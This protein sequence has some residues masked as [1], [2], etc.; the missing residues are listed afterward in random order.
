MAFLKA[1]KEHWEQQQFP[2]KGA[3]ILVAVSGGRDS[4][5]LAFV[6]LQCEQPIVVAH[7]NYQL[8]GADSDADEALVT[9]WCA[10]NKVPLFVK[11]FD[12][13][14]EMS[15]QKAGV[16]ETARKLRYDWF[17]ELCQQEQISAIATAHHANDNAETL[18]INLCKGTGISGMHG[19]PAKNGAVIRPFLFAERSLIDEFVASNQIPYRDDGS[20]SSEDYLRNKIRHRALPA[21]E[22]CF[23]QLISNLN[24]SIQNLKGAEKIYRKGI[25]QMKKKLYDKRGK[26]I[27]IPVLRLQKLEGIDAIC[28]EIA[29]DFG[30]SPAQA[31][32]LKKLIDRESGKFISSPTHKIIKNRDFLI[33]T[34]QE[35][36]QQ[37]FFLIQDLAQKIITPEGLFTIQQNSINDIITSKANIAQID[38]DQLEQP[39][40]LRRGKKSDYFYPLGMQLKKKKLSKFLADQKIPVPLRERIW[41][42]ESNK[43]IVWV[44]G[45]RID[46][47]F[48]IKEKTKNIVQ[49]HFLPK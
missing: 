32:D 38:A 48:K 6:L 23:P 16:Q 47:R 24:N 7:C 12:T 30:F 49:F 27:Y 22:E 29:T 36:L 25:E 11:R 31:Q 46:D 40:I 44:C 26:D 33:V 41:V 20:N 14:S 35:A 37:D 42:V 13:K 43:K 4:M 17:A 3:K 2:Q 10:Q 34:Q 45:Q 19:I 9:G 21:L 18:L 1:F 15:I 8:R 5:A 39:L 28:F